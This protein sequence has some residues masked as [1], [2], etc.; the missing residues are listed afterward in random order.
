M[1][2]GKGRDRLLFLSSLSLLSL[3]LLFPFFSLYPSVSERVCLQNEGLW[4]LKQRIIYSHRG[5]RERKIFHPSPSSSSR[6]SFFS[7]VLHPHP[8]FSPSFIC[9][10]FLL[11]KVG[12]EKRR[13]KEDQT[14]NASFFLSLFHILRPPPLSGFER[15]KKIGE[16]F[17]YFD[18][19]SSPSI[20]MRSSSEEKRRQKDETKRTDR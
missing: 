9:V 14:C 20:L 10:H 1:A 4:K 6:L 3:T 12:M 17:L 13:G 7:I 2:E 19:F 16:F 18:L 8:S 11:E 15:E 5:W